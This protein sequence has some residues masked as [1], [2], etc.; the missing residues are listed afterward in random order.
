[1]NP[2]LVRKNQIE[3]IRAA[4]IKANPEIAADTRGTKQE[5]L[6]RQ[7]QVFIDM[8]HG[9]SSDDRNTTLTPVAIQL[10]RVRKLSFALELMFDRPIRLADVLLVMNEN[11]GAERYIPKYKCIG[12]DKEL[13][14]DDTEYP[15]YA[16]EYGYAKMHKGCGHTA[17]IKYASLSSDIEKVLKMYNLRTDDLEQQSD[18]TIA[19]LYELVPHA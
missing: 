12:C 1:M 11:A 6:N 4:C 18:E 16:Y 15:A 19:F 10:E 14:E 17:E 13:R 8:C 7:Y 3:V 9:V 2:Q 5:E